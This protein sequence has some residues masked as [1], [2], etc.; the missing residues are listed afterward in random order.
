MMNAADPVGASAYLDRYVFA[1]GERPFCCWEQ[2]LHDRNCRF[3]SGLDADYY[4]QF[5]SFCAAQLDG[6]SKLPE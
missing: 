5:A 6:E 2:D 3:L 1:V 4:S